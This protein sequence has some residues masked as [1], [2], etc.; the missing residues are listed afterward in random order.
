[1]IYINRLHMAKVKEYIVTHA[2]CGFRSCKLSTLHAVRRLDAGSPQPACL[3]AA[4]MGFELQGTEEPS[5]TLIRCPVRG[6][7]FFPNM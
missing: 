6:I 1:M 4:S 2:Y 7:T 3:H 5:H